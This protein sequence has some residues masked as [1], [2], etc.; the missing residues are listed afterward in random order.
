[1]SSALSAQ[2]EGKATSG[3]DPVAVTDAYSQVIQPIDIQ[4]YD[5]FTVYVLNSGGGA[6]NDLLNVI[7]ETAP[8]ELVGV[9]WTEVGDVLSVPLIATVASYRSFSGES[10]KLIRIR[11]R[12]AAAE[13]TTARFWVSAGGHP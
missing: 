4:D 13:S 5:R 8:V 11:A 7:V 3:V 12:C 6:G 9:P 2:F 1:M 10:L